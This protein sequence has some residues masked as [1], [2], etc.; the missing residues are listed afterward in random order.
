MN[1]QYLKSFSIYFSS[2]VIF[3][4]YLLFIKN[5]S[6]VRVST[7][8]MYFI[9]YLLIPTIAIIFS[10]LVLEKHRYL[11]NEI[12]GFITFLI[13][14][15]ISDKMWIIEKFIDFAEKSGTINISISY[16]IGINNM[17]GF[18]LIVLWILMVTHYTE[19]IRFK[20]SMKNEDNN[21]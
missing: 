6:V 14:G 3:S 2:T 18:I 11:I 16:N 21:F 12:F 1:N 4:L 5:L 17:M 7:I 15:I 19:K 20:R 13:N 10:T 8:L 9:L